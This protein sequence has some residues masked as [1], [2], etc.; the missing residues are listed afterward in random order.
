MSAEQFY[1]NGLH[2]FVQG[3]LA[4]AGHH[5]HLSGAP[6]PAEQHTICC[7]IIWGQRRAGSV[8]T[9]QVQG[10]LPISRRIATSCPS[11]RN[12]NWLNGHV[13][14]ITVVNNRVTGVRLRDGTQISAETVL[15]G[16][17]PQATFIGMLDRLTCRHAS[18]QC[19]TSKCA[20]RCQTQSALRGLPTVI[21]APNGN[22]DYLR[23]RI[24]ISPSLTYLN[25]PTM[26]QIR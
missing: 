21:A 26:R 8:A 5:R 7:T 4:R 6:I 14:Q 16:A 12:R 25:V 10:A 1:H 24:Q 18:K 23:G 19:D 9:A 15:S 2:P 17:D 11:T 3:V 20:R 22:T 13:D